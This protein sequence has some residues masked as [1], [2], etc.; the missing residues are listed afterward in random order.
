MQQFK[1]EE[2]SLTDQRGWFLATSHT[3]SVPIQQKGSISP[4]APLGLGPAPTSTCCQNGLWWPWAPSWHML[5]AHQ[6]LPQCRQHRCLQVAKQCHGQSRHKHG[7]PKTQPKQSPS[8]YHLSKFQLNPSAKPNVRKNR[9]TQSDRMPIYSSR[10]T[11]W[12]CCTSCLHARALLRRY[13]GREGISSSSSQTVPH[14]QGRHSLL[15]GHLKKTYCIP[16]T[17]TFHQNKPSWAF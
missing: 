11:H 17:H 14:T 3:P 13:A 2:K 8:N 4:T 10:W 15:H 6:Q 7:A 16:Q 1:E 5:G 12:A 9:L